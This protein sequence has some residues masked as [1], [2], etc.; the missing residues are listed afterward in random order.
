MWSLENFFQVSLPKDT[1][2]SMMKRK[3]GYEHVTPRSQMYLSW[4]NRGMDRHCL[5][6]PGKKR[7]KKENNKILVHE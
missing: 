5:L 4:P 3:Q 6:P 7:R 2:L 1:S